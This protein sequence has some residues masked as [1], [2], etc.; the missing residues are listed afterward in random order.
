[1]CEC[2]C[3]CM[4]VCVCVCALARACVCEREK[5]PQDPRPVHSVRQ[6]LTTVQV[7]CV[8]R[9]GRRLNFLNIFLYC[10]HHVYRVFSPICN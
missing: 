8:S 10:H 9:V 5:L 6:G 2:A 1:M 7:V 3:H 4:C